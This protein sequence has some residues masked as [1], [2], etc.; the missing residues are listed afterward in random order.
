MIQ[1]L[2]EII[3]SR[4]KLSERDCRSQQNNKNEKY[5]FVYTTS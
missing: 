5:I 2:I 1:T 3:D 4:R